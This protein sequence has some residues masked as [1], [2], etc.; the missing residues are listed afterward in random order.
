MPFSWF[1][2]ISTRFIS[3]NPGPSTT[4]FTQQPRLSVQT[5]TRAIMAAPE[6]TEASSTHHVLSAQYKSP[7]NESFRLN[8]RL[9]A[10]ATSEPADRASYLSALQKQT[11]EL[12]TSINSLLTFRMEEDK[13]K[14]ATSNSAK[15][16]GA[17]VV[18]EANEEDN[19]GEEV[20]EEAS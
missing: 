8:H 11:A 6:S 17:K 16:V 20:V 15:S 12:Q 13:A 19:Y 14:E 9:H 1:H 3:R 18:E 7:T 5:S 10:P 2:V 4:I